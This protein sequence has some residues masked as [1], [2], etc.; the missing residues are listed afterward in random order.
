ME[1][2]CRL[3]FFSHLQMSR[4]G[5]RLLRHTC[6][7]SSTQLAVLMFPYNTRVWRAQPARTLPPRFAVNQIGCP[8]PTKEITQIY[9]KPVND[10]YCGAQQRAFFTTP[11]NK[12]RREEARD[13]E[14][15]SN[16]HAHACRYQHMRRNKTWWNLC[17]FIIIK[18]RDCY[19]DILRKKCYFKENERKSLLFPQNSHC[20]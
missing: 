4:D 20:G 9:A 14:T 6:C 7:M 2:C 13:S 8:A 12:T 5:T 19:K 15:C 17:T 16:P 3:F 18:P 11:Q 1:T 10:L